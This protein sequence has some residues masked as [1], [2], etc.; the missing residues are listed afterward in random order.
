MLPPQSNAFWVRYQ[1][2]E[3]ESVEETLLLV[4]KVLHGD[5]RTKNPRKSGF[6]GGTLGD[7]D[8]NR[9]LD[10]LICTPNR[11]AVTSVL[12]PHKW[13]RKGARGTFRDGKY[14]YEGESVRRFVKRWCDAMNV[15]AFT[16]EVGSRDEA[17]RVLNGYYER[18]NRRMRQK[19]SAKPL[20]PGG[21][22]RRELDSSA[23]SPSSV[24]TVEVSHYTGSC[25]ADWE[26]S[27]HT[28]VNVKFDLSL[29]VE[30]W[31]CF[32][33]NNVVELTT[34]FRSCYGFIT[35]GHSVY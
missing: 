20:G 3:D 10:L 1:P 11:V 24:P 15:R 29:P 14:P 34:S 7:G 30:G 31:Y 27:V 21:R 16:R 23:L 6:F 25:A 18:Q 4:D 12:N 5:C 8:G 35:F 9:V 13:R 19:R 28:M 33:L 2:E 22:K 17:N 26:S 32:L